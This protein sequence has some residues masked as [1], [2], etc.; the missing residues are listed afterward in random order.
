MGR[1]FSE[2]ISQSMR[3]TTVSTY[4]MTVVMFLGITMIELVV[5]VPLTDLSSLDLLHSCITT[6]IT[7]TTTNGSHFGSELLRT[8]INMNPWKVV[9]KV[10]VDN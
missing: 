10:D 6:T 2:V 9:D 8:N 5:Y 3:M 4:F 7:T 1:L